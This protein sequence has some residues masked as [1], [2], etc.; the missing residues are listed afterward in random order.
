MTRD[1]DVHSTIVEVPKLQICRFFNASA[2]LYKRVR[3]SVR[4]SVGP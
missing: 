2:H 1:L 4:P 3:P